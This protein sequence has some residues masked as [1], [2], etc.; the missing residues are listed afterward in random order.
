MA[1]IYYNITR[2]CE[3]SIKQWLE[4]ELKDGEW[5]CRVELDFS[6]AYKTSLPLPCIVINADNNPDVKLEVGS[7]KLSNFFDIEFRIF[8]TGEG[9]RKDLRDWLRDKVIEGIPYNE[10]II[11]NKINEIK[12]KEEVGRISIISI[13]TNRRELHVTDGTDERDKH[14]SL[15]S[16]KCRI[17]KI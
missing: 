5:N 7:N 10:Y 13:I 12:H 15:L 2:N 16:F 17:V 3:A 14:R 4:E 9:Q 6:S 1:D 8:A 11:D